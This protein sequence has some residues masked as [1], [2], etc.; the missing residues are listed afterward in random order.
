MVTSDVMV[1][2]VKRKHFGHPNRDPIFSLESLK[3]P[4]ATPFWTTTL[5]GLL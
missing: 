1:K 5:W 2:I 3:H 4:L